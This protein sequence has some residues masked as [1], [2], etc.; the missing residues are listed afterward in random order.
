MA[1]CTSCSSA[2]D[3]VVC[4]SCQQA[5]MQEAIC[6]IETLQRELRTVKTQLSFCQV[7]L[8]YQLKRWTGQERR[9]KSS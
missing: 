8:N 9:K 2:A 7:A 3:K 6:T 1:L 4:A 5:Q